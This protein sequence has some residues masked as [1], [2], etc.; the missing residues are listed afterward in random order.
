MKQVKTN[1]EIKKIAE[2]YGNGFIGNSISYVE[3]NGEI[4]GFSSVGM[5]PVIQIHS[6]VRNVKDLFYA[7]YG[8]ALSVAQKEI[9]VLCNNTELAEQLKKREGFKELNFK[10]LI[11]EV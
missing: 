11:K 2:F 7:A 1:E 3:E 6:D 10:I 4:K 9:F 8:K 5:V